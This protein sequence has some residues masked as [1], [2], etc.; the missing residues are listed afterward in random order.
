MGTEAVE[1]WMD[2]LTTFDESEAAILQGL[3]ESEGIPCKIESCR[4]SQIPVAVG[5]LGELKVYVRQRDF[6]RASKLLESTR[7]EP[8]DED[9][10][11]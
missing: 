1:R 5:E 7:A 9:E 2:I 3:F 10:K 8:P 4:V 11:P 6:D